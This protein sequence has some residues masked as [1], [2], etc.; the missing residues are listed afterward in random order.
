V[1]GTELSRRA[2]QALLVAACLLYLGL[3]VFMATNKLPWCDEGWY[4]GPAINLITTGSM[5]TPNIYFLQ[6][7][8]E[9]TYWEMPVFIV[10]SAAWLKLVGIGLLQI[11]TLNIL[12]GL[13]AILL[14]VKILRQLG[15][16]A[17]VGAIAAT[18]LAVDYMFMM[19]A[20]WAR[21]DML[22]LVFNLTA[23]A[24]Y[25]RLR[26]TN[27]ALAIAISNTAIMLAGLTHPN[28]GLLALLGFGALLYRDRTQLRPIHSAAFIAP[29]LLGSLAWGLYIAQ[30]PADFASQFSQNAHGRF[31]GLL[32]PFAAIHDEIVKRYLQT[33]GLGPHLAGTSRFVVVKAVVLLVYAIAVF[34]VFAKPNLRRH[35]GVSHLLVLLGLY[36]FFYTFLENTRTTYYLIWIIPVYSTL[37]AIWLVTYWR[38]GGLR[39]YAAISLTL[40]M[41]VVQMAAIYTRARQNPS[42]RGYKNAVAFL[43]NHDA[44]NARSFASTEFGYALGFIPGRYTDDE[45]LGIDSG[46]RPALVVA[47][48]RYYQELVLADKNSKPVLLN[49]QRFLA[50][51]CT[52]EYDQ[53]RYQIY[54]CK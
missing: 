18:L 21:A 5:G 52:L 19:D 31:T 22:G 48:P 2:P 3:A 37:V 32:H 9:H 44:V 39:R 15:L 12:L 29:Y 4:G 16:E 26:E 11:R 6:G 10:A 14:W 43:K 34:H 25:L 50:T 49:S 42:M 47:D 28:A 13:T 20:T 38:A 40:L 33:Y 51:N 46:I 36:L 8:R 24:S 7:I 53:D 54:R 45:T 41:A 30:A 35:R 23:Y 27:F 1:N 17:W